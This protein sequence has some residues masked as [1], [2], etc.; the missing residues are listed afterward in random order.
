MDV[1]Q[2]YDG[3]KLYSISEEQKEVTVSKVSANSDDLLTP[4][5]VFEM[6]KTGY[7]ISWDGEKTVNGRKLTFVK[8]TPKNNSEITSVIVGIDKAKKEMVQMIEKTK[9][10]T[11]TTVSVTKQINNIIIASDILK[12]NKNNFK[13][14]Y[15]SEI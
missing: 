13:N 15:I 8:L 11:T 9:N 3:V 12:F 14:Y 10:N 4:T 5:K 2:I 6:Y 1:K 7:N